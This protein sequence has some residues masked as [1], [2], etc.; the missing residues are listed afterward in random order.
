MEHGIKGL[1]ALGLLCCKT[2]P[3]PAA[4]NLTSKDH[5]E[6]RCTIY[7]I[8]YSI[9]LKLTDGTVTSAAGFYNTLP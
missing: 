8:L 2:L 5:K 4:G 6:H 7:L 3:V 1:S 9:I